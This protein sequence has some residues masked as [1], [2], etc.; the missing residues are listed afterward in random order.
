MLPMRQPDDQRRVREQW[1]RNLRK[2]LRAP[3]YPLLSRS[4]FDLGLTRFLLIDIFIQASIEAVSPQSNR[5]HFAGL[6]QNRIAVG[7]RS[8]DSHYELA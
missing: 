1:P 3:D 2:D 5:A 8:G 4:S 7:H 6:V